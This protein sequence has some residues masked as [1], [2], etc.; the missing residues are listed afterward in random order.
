MF[1][2]VVKMQASSAAYITGYQNKA[3]QEPP[4]L[5]PYKGTKVP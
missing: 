3:I 4:G 5:K 2:V 1:G